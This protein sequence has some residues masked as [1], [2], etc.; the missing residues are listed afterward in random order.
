[1]AQNTPEFLEIVSELLH[2]D[3]YVPW[4]VQMSAAPA[5]STALATYSSHV[6]GHKNETMNRLLVRLSNTK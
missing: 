4:P 6:L 5:P 1:M 3:K 2:L